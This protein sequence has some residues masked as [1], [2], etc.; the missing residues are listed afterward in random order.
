MMPTATGSVSADVRPS[1]PPT[2]TPAEEERE[3]WHGEA[4]RDGAEAVLEGFC[5]ARAGVGPAADL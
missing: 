5:Q 3:D 2:A 1:Q 4:G